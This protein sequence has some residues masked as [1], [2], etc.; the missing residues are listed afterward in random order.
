MTDPATGRLRLAIPNKGRMV[1]GTDGDFTIVAVDDDWVDLRR[2]DRPAY[3]FSTS[4]RALEDFAPGCAFHQSPAS[5]FTKTTVCSLR[6]DT[7]RVTL[8]ELTLVRTVSGSVK[9]K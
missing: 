6:T 9:L 2:G 7:G 8:S 3:R 5:H 1:V 4:A